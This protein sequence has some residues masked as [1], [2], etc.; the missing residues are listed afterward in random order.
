VRQEGLCGAHRILRPTHRNANGSAANGRWRIPSCARPRGSDAVRTR[1][2][3]GSDAV[4]CRERCRAGTG[5][6][7]VLLPAR[8]GGARCR[9][10]GAGGA[11]GA[12]RPT[13]P[14][15]QW[16][17]WMGSRA[18]TLRCATHGRLRRLAVPKAVLGLGPDPNPQPPARVSRCLKRPRGTPSTKNG[19]RRC[20][21]LRCAAM[22]CAAV[23]EPRYVVANLM[24]MTKYRFRVTTVTNVRRHHATRRDS[25][26]PTQR[27]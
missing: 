17:V 18:S 3:R 13:V 5:P 26:G 23:Q 6:P 14:G 16:S 20:A 7:A 22:R 10:G 19:R 11:G 12:C 25:A 2:G 1:C 9:A 21:A 8:R 15:L 27:L 4:R 24:P